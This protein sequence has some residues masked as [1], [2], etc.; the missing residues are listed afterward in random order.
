MPTQ[1]CPPTPPFGCGGNRPCRGLAQ[2]TC[3]VISMTCATIHF[4]PPAYIDTFIRIE[5]LHISIDIL[6]TEIRKPPS[7]EREDLRIAL[8]NLHDPSESRVT[9]LVEMEPGTGGLGNR[10]R[11][12][13]GAALLVD[14]GGLA[15]VACED[16]FMD[17]ATSH[18]PPP[19]RT[20][21][22]HQF[23][24]IYYIFPS[25]SLR[26]RSSSILFP[27][28]RRIFVLLKEIFMIPA[29]SS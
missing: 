21:L 27:R 29:I 16:I 4:P 17:C 11:P 25:N 15:Q 22:I 14:T 7:A 8:A 3:D 1:R 28:N 10:H 5:V 26:H 12:L 19:P 20:H 13:A 9:L 6:S 23:E 2:E 24:F 18:G